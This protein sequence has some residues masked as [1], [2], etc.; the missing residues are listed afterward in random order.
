MQFVFSAEGGPS[1]ALPPPGGGGD[2]DEAARRDEALFGGEGRLL[3]PAR[4]L[5]GRTSLAEFLAAQPRRDITALE[6][7]MS[8]ADAMQLLAARRVLG[9]PLFDVLKKR[10]ITFL[11]VATLLRAF[12]LHGACAPVF[13]VCAY[14]RAYPR[15]NAAR[16]TRRAP[17]CVVACVPEVAVARAHACCAAAG[18]P[19]NADAATADADQDSGVGDAAAP[20]APALQAAGEKF[21]RWPLERVRP[22]EGARAPRA[23]G[24]ACAFAPA[25][26][27][28]VGTRRTL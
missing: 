26:R 17:A 7:R 14:R 19:A 11:D 10:F 18:L 4:A 23:R 24:V 25:T 15:L 8:V 6:L 13:R 27:V 21:G 22:P 16:R 20:S 5:L 28:S 2:A 1:E 3:A 9:G 12:I